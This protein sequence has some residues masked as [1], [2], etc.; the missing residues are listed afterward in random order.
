[1]VASTKLEAPPGISIRSLV[2]GF[3]LT[4]QTEGKSPG[5]VEYYLDNLK[6][7]IWY[8]EKEGWSDD[9]RLLTEWQI[10]EFLG[11]VATETNC[12][13]REGNGSKTSPPSTS[14]KAGCL[15]EVGESKNV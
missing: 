10:R 5:T 11:Y 15:N 12:W 2:K 1:M 3:V 13:G 7:L 9:V 8:A 4:K 6:R 14:G